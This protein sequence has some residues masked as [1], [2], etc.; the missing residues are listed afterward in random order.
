[1]KAI[2]DPMLNSER[3]AGSVLGQ[4]KPDTLLFLNFTEWYENYFRDLDDDQKLKQVVEIALKPALVYEQAMRF[5]KAGVKQLILPKPVVINQRQLRK[6]TEAVR[7]HQVK[8]AVASQ[9]H[10]SDFPKIIQREIK[11]LAHNSNGSGP[12][13]V[14]VEVEF[15]KENG[16]AYNTAPPLL[17]LPHVLQLLASIGLVDFDQHSP[18]VRGTNTL[19]DLVYRPHNVKQGIH[20]RADVDWQPPPS[21]K[22]KYTQWDVQERKLKIY[23]ADGH[24]DPELE[25]DFWIKFDRSGDAVIRPGQLTIRDNCEFGQSQ[26]LA[27][28]FVEDQLLN[29][30]H[31]IYASFWQD[32]GQFQSDQNILTLERYQSIGKQLMLI[33][34]EWESTIKPC[35]MLTPTENGQQPCRQAEF[36]PQL[37][38]NFTYAS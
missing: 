7:K 17:E 19:V 24:A 16:L 32:F 36:A 12:R 29:M 30:N 26:E 3:F 21:I 35:P 13:L 6:L 11:H 2:V 33:Q 18:E 9:W 14:R 37:S 1:V 10:Y 4:E 25:V 15:S 34:A 31:K 38:G 5:I 28:N 22:R 23:I 8:V 20:V 27:F